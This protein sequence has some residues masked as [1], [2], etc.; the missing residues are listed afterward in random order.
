MHMPFISVHFVRSTGSSAGFFPDNTWSISPRYK[1]SLEFY[2]LTQSVNRQNERDNIR[3][4][5]FLSKNEI[6]SSRGW[7][8]WDQ[9]SDSCFIATDKC[10]LLFILLFSDFQF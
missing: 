9:K 6:D 1:K 5:N 2:L 7:K 8:L 10:P 3:G 4:K